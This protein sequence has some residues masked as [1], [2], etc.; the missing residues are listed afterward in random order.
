MGNNEK[1]ANLGIE[2]M[3]TNYI[4]LIFKEIENI[5]DLG[6]GINVIS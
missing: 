6:F 1:V 3:S 2:L 5:D 4:V